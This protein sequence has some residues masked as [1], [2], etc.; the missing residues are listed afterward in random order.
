MTISD[1]AL[2][3]LDDKAA[4]AK[5]KRLDL[6]AHLDSPVCDS[7]AI[8]TAKAP[9]VQHENANASASSYVVASRLNRA[10][11]EDAAKREAMLSALQSLRGSGR[12]FSSGRIIRS[13]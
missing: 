2:F 12:G 3:L 4:K 9:A 7:L 1:Q 10:N 13:S 8:A 6:F 5:R 11:Y